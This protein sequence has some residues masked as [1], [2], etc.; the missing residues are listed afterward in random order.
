MAAETRIIIS[1]RDNATPVIQRVEKELTGLRQR[2]DS[3]GALAGGAALAGSLI[4]VGD[5]ALQASIKMQKLETAYATISG[6][7]AASQLEYLRQEAERLGLSYVDT[8]AQAKGF[9]AA[10]KGTKLEGATGKQIFSGVMEGAAALGLGTDEVQ[11]M[12]LALSQMASKGKVQA[13]ELRGQLGERLPG[14]FQIAARAMG[15]TTAALDKFMADGKLFSEDFLPKFGAQMHK[16]FGVASQKAATMAQAALNQ[17]SSAWTEAKAAFSQTDTAVTGIRVVTEALK[18]FSEEYGQTSQGTEPLS[19]DVGDGLRS[20]VGY[21]DEGVVALGA[22]TVARRLA[23]TETMKALAADKQ[24]MGLQGALR[25]RILASNKAVNEKVTAERQAAKAALDTAK[26]EHAR[27]AALL[28]TAQTD[29]QDAQSRYAQTKQRVPD[30]MTREQR[31]ALRELTDAQRRA[32]EISGRFAAS[33][34]VL[35]AAM[36]RSRRAIRGTSAALDALRSM[37]AGKAALTGLQSAAS[38]L[39]GVLGGPW[40]AALTAAA[41]GI[42]SLHSAARESEAELTRYKQ[43]IADVGK[44]GKTAAAGLDKFQQS[45]LIAAKN[46]AADKLEEARKKLQDFQTSLKDTGLSSVGDA[47][48]FRER[49]FGYDE[50]T[51]QSA[52]IMGQVSSGVLEVKEAFKQV[53]TLKEQFGNTE[54]IQVLYD[55]LVRLQGQQIEEQRLQE[56]LV[57]AQ[58]AYFSSLKMEEVFLDKSAAAVAYYNR[59]LQKTISLRAQMEYSAVY[60]GANDA[61]FKTLISKEQEKAFLNSLKGRQQYIA[62]QLLD[63]KTGLK[64]NEVQEALRSGFKNLSPMASEYAEAA[65]RAYKEPKTSTRGASRI[66]NAQRSLEALRAEIDK[67]NGAGSAADVTLTKKLNEIEKIGKSAKLSGTELSGLQEQYAQAFATDALRKFD[68]ELLKLSGDAQAIRL[69]GIDKQMAEWRTQLEALTKV[70]QLSPEDMESGLAKMRAGLEK[71]ADYKNLQTAVNFYKELGDL[72]GDYTLSVEKQNQLIALQAEIHR[73]NGIPPDLAAE[74]ELLQKINNAR[75]PLSGLQRAMR[76]TASESGNL[77]SIMESSWTSMSKGMEDSI[78]R[79]GTTSKLTIEDV[80]NT[81]VEM[82]WRIAAQNIVTGPM[83]SMFSSLLGGLFGGGGGGGGTSMMGNVPLYSGGYVGA[84]GGVLG[85]GSLSAYSGSIVSRPTLFSYATDGYGF[86]P[87]DRFARG[88]GLMGEAGPEA[89]LP[90]TRINGKLGVRAELPSYAALTAS[91]A[92]QRERRYADMHTASLMPEFQAMLARRERQNAA[93]ERMTRKS[94]GAE[95]AVARA[96]AGP[97]SGR[98]EVTVNVYENTNK[99]R[100]EVTQTP[101]ANGTRIDV[102]ILDVVNRDI[103]QGGRTARTLQTAY[104]L[105]RK[106]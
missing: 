79:W 53:N 97:P 76:K 88:A 12:L 43:L 46:T 15:M 100:A 29:L 73:Q 20:V 45:A 7:G 84:R 16:E 103:A 86:N 26:A 75:D 49:V 25:E 24:M 3:M 35:G 13:E 80:G 87:P 101:T 22:W 14:A 36:D 40:G 82:L 4:G 89:I 98:G 69:H 33:Q 42:Y 38:G 99:A 31:K 93:V 39:I 91:L 54:P 21:L 34:N 60:P 52:K 44:E 27:N 61:V 66:E 81:M 57:A 104:G 2:V 102:T 17:L 10:I 106:A 64:L 59:Q 58:D 8:A 90:L 83:N 56:E 63:P 9:F 1:A 105:K 78:V 5:A 85:G 47:A 67:L 55:A 19:K 95:A 48:S 92:S 41:L 96:A 77:A 11:G 28:R 6:K 68:D 70:G 62:K 72:S 71:Q 30:V 32:T 50:S 65:G 94:G 18:A 37:S 74:W 51:L 23:N